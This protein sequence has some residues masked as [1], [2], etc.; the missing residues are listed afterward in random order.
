MS[1]RREEEKGRNVGVR[2][3]VT[4]LA[5]LGAGAISL[6]GNALTRVAVPW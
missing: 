5:L 3:R 1:A 2:S 6:T 4:H